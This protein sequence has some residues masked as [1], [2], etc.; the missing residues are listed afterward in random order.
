MLLYW[1]PVVKKL[2]EQSKQRLQENNKLWWYVAI[3]L[4]SDDTSSEVYV[5]LK[6]KYAQWLGI[7]ANIKL[8]KDRD[9][10]ETIQEIQQCNEDESCLWILVQLPLADHLIEH[11]E[12]ILETIDP[13]KDID[14]LTS[15]VY[16][17]AAFG[18]TNLMWATPK[19]AFEILDHYKLWDLSWKVVLIITQSNL[20]WKWLTME[21]MHRKATIIS[22]NH[23]TDPEVLKV[24]FARADVV[25]SATGVKNLISWWLIVDSWWLSEKVLIDIW[26]GSDEDG[27]HGDMD[28]RYFEDKVKGITPVPGGVG[29]V[30][31][32][33]LF[34]NI[35]KD[36]KTMRPWVQ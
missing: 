32:A 16:G 31:V 28:W 8:W 27:P 29:P 18:Y 26:R 30:T 33:S 14:G 19:S 10:H 13:S 23:L 15:A 34:D 22:A 17:K 4:L 5:G 35:I 2:K 20:I 7:H 21:C 12:E 6:A 3:F 11:Q 24:F 25:F 9:K 1:K 36:N